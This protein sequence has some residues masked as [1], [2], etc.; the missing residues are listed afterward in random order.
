[1]N[2]RILFIDI[3]R[4]IAMAWIV[5]WWHL[6]QYSHPDYNNLYTFL[7]DE[8][9]TMLMLGVFFYISGLL[10]STKDITTRAHIKSFYLNRL[11]RFYFLYALSVLS[12]PITGF[13]Q[14]CGTIL[15]LLTLT[16][17]F[18]PPPVTLWF[19]GMLA[20]FYLLTPLIKR[21]IIWSISLF[22]CILVVHHILEITVDSRIYLYLPIYCF[23]IYTYWYTNVINVVNSICKKIGIITIILI[24]S[25]ISLILFY[26][27]INNRVFLFPFI[28]FGGILLLSFS[29]VIEPLVS[30]RLLHYLSYGSFCAYLFHRQIYFLFKNVYTQHV[31][32]FSLWI[33]ITIMFPICIIVSYFI[34]RIYDHAI[35]HR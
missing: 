35:K 26:L 29:K 19:M 23:G 14:D 27:S 13:N 30:R 28:C 21:S 25:L 8:C 6:I 18:T 11:K 4:V 5:G 12:F 17:V 15:S 1:M 3:A 24:V 9:I 10:L 22:I 20:F 34:Q 32:T 7:G 2:E 16:T 31:G 33:C